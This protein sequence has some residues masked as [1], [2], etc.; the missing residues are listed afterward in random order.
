MGQDIHPVFQA[1]ALRLLPQPAEVKSVTSGT[2]A[3]LD[4]NLIFVLMSSDVQWIQ[5]P[6]IEA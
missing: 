4:E 6:S 2:C 1:L 3:R 5:G